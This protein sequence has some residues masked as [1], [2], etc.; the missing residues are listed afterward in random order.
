M[1]YPWIKDSQ[2]LPSD[3]I[4]Y[5][6]VTSPNGLY[7]TDG[8]SNTKI[9]PTSIT[10]NTFNGALNGNANTA[11]NIS[12]G[13]GGQIL[14]QSAVDTTAKLANGDAGKF[15]KSQGITLPPIWDNLIDPPLNDV[16]SA[17]NTT[18]NSATF[19]SGTQSTVISGNGI[20]YTDGTYSTIID[21]IIT[22]GKTDETISTSIDNI[23]IVIRDT[24]TDDSVTIR[25]NSLSI[26]NY[27]AER[28]I[29][30]ENALIPK[31]EVITGTNTATLYANEIVFNNLGNVTLFIL[32][33]PINFDFSNFQTKL[34]M[35]T[36]KSY[37]YCI[38]GKCK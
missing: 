36:I 38:K 18:T 25:N 34:S 15:L 3:E 11:T 23:N 28:S 27:T 19:T 26:Q 6:A 12:G 35:L 33:V 16:L 24:N 32:K 14:Y 2:Y 30:L 1:S 10:S 17:G 5:L 4:G 31:V 37:D 20:T 22:V 21:N 7:L 13:L 9:T 8:S 29:T